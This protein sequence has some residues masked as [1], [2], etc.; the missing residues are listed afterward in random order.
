MKTGSRILVLVLF[1]LSGALGLIYEVT[2]MRLLRLAMG[3]TVFTS[4][5]VLTTFMAGLALGEVT[6]HR[7]ILQLPRRPVKKSDRLQ[8][9]L[10]LNTLPK[11]R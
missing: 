8:G 1:F 11:T 2:W 4:A 6:L 10:D 5:T 3:N 7:G 9:T